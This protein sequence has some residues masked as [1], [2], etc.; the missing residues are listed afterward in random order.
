[1]RAVL[2][3]VALQATLGVQ[4]AA[5]T[6]PALRP[7]PAGAHARLRAGRPRP[8]GEVWDGGQFASCCIAAWMAEVRA[9][10]CC[11]P[12]ISAQPAPLHPPQPP[13]SLLAPLQF[14]AASFAEAA[15]F[16]RS[17]VAERIRRSFDA[18]V[19]RSPIG[20]HLV[21]SWVHMPGCALAAALGMQALQLC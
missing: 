16:N 6:R 4:G 15:A 11:C 18:M 5:G 9:R 13:S 10:P 19:A 20:G 8:P 17:E 7:G 12:R 3:R 21:S 2:P 14:A 1:M